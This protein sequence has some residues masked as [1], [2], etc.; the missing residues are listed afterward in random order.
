MANPIKRRKARSFAIQAIYQWQMTQDDIANIE[1]H[2][3][4]EI[5]DKESPMMVELAD[6]VED[7]KL[8]DMDRPY[9]S[10][11]ITGVALNSDKLDELMKP[12]LARKIEELDQVEKAILRLALYEMT[13]SKSVPPKVAI[14]EAIE[15]A[16]AFGGE[17]SHKFINAVLDKVIKLRERLDNNQ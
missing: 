14:N 13:I 11:L 12:Y 10:S 9:F 2:F 4:A 1:H 16:K 7:L 17:D 15:L 5:A 3:L 8:G 6:G